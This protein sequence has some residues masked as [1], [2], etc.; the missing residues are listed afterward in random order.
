MLKGLLW[1][2]VVFSSK[3]NH[4]DRVSFAEKA[5]SSKNSYSVYIFTGSDWC[6][7]C[8]RFEK[9]VLKDSNFIKVC[10]SLSLRIEILDFPQRTKQSQETIKRNGV[11]SDKFGFSGDFPT[12]VIYSDKSE[13]FRTLAYKN[14]DV[15]GFMTVLLPELA[16]LNE[17]I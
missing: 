16:K 5:D 14:E 9:N 12:V 17:G 7:N 3:P 6:A 8:H 2:L 11:L 13:K 15:Y 1:L 10:D 4:S